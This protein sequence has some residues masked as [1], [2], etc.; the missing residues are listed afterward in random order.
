MLKDSR[1]YVAGHAGLAGSAIVRKLANEGYSNVVSKSRAEL[2]L[3][4]QE[5]VDK[6]FASVQPQYVFLAA[7]KVG[8]ILANSTRPAEFIR[9]NLLIQTHVIDA[10]YRN[11][12]TT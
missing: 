2:D 9:D 12:C 11:G 8:G 6:F 3:T 1:I 5:A 7:A 10:A 4:R